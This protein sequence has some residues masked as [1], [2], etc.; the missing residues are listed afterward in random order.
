MKIRFLKGTTLAGGKPVNPGDVHE[1]SAEDAHR[2]VKIYRDAEFIT[3][4]AV[5]P[6][7]AQQAKTETVTAVAGEAQAEE[8]SKKGKKKTI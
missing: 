3:E 2:F 1:V 8:E 6:V 7:E 4:A 5:K